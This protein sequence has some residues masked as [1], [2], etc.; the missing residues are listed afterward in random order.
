MNAAA[1]TAPLP[2]ARPGLA[3]QVA[4]ITCAA[5]A[6][7]V[8]ASGMFA[9]GIVRGAY[10]AQARAALRQEAALVA[11]LLG[12]PGVAGSTRPGRPVGRL[13]ARTGVQVVRLTADGSLGPP[14]SPAAPPLDPADAAASATG[15]VVSSTRTLAGQRYLVE[16]QPVAGD[17]GVVLLQRAAEA[18]GGD[19]AVLRRLGLALALGLLVATGLAVLLARRLA[20]PLV[21]AARTAHRL[22]RGERGLRLVV[23][24]PAEVAE[25]SHSL[26]T[27]TDA[28]AR[29]EGRQAQFLLSVSHELRTP[30][31]AVRGFAE[32]LEDGVTNNTAEVVQAGAVIRAE[33]QRLE[34][35]V[36][37]LLDLARLG[38]ED[39]RVDVVVVDLR[40]LVA[41]A[42]RVWRHRGEAIG[43]DVTTELPPLAVT[44]ATDPVRLRQVLDGLAENALRV[45]PHGRPLVLALQA[46]ATSA[47][48]EVRDGGPGLTDDDLAV[49]FERSVLYDRY[50]GVRRVGTGV[51]LALVAG[52]VARLGGTV[53]AGHAAEGG[54]VFTV[55]LPL[56]APPTAAVG[57]FPIGSERAGSVG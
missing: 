49:A 17:G 32:A 2:R 29:S 15:Q 43:V 39:F 38:A 42:G 50:R 45:T 54:A 34:R 36:S 31:T 57:R 1:A 5:A 40:G 25:V 3:R 13:L 55:E 8:L 56:A 44:V 51:G 24:G 35:L 12:Q 27:L 21:Q 19:R 47:T 4:V 28:L 14:S 48:V 18:R 6:A 16:G 10:D 23:E 46:G 33:A 22:A 30:L 20:R 26:N 52:L 7:A 41:E 53:R 11:R 9:V 37:D